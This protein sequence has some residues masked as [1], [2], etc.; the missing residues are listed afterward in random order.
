MEARTLTELDARAYRSLR[1]E[2]SKEEW[3]VGTP[4]L[5]RDLEAL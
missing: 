4:I 5:Q 1:I 3:W 2:A